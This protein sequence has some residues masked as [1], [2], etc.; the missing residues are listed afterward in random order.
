LRREK[1]GGGNSTVPQEWKT[2]VLKKLGESTAKG[3]MNRITPMFVTARWLMENYEPLVEI[4]KK[5]NKKLLKGQS[6]KGKKA[7]QYE[8][9]NKD[10]ITS[11]YMTA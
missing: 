7:R 5:Y 10:S 2:A 8:P 11:G 4:D 6:R 3:D 1:K 9:S